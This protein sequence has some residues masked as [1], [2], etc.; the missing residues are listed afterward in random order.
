MFSITHKDL[1]SKSYELKET[2]VWNISNFSTRLEERLFS[3][4]FTSCFSNQ[5]V[6]R[7]CVYPNGSREVDRGHVS[8]FLYNSAD[9]KNNVT[10]NYVFAIINGDGHVTSENK[11]TKSWNYMEIN[12]N[13]GS[14]FPR[15]FS[16]DKLDE[17]LTNGSLRL[18]IELNYEKF[19]TCLSVYHVKE[20]T[21]NFEIAM[22]SNY[23]DEDPFSAA[24]S[25]VEKLSN[26]ERLIDADD[27]DFTIEFDS[28]Q[29]IKVSY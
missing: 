7:L 10:V 1:V 26:F 8:L 11:S 12:A 3:E 6:W 21:Q 17:K 5:V 22:Q 24:T 13:N 4:P 23:Y 9:C 18:R 16:R 15:L 14:G 20:V 19:D 28:D 27:G 29:K 25:A 2:L